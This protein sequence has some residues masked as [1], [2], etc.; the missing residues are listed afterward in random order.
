MTRRL[1]AGYL[2]LV[3]LVLLGLEIP[4]GLLFVRAETSRL[5]NGIER[6]AGMLAELAEERIEENDTDELPELAADY[7][8]R[9]GARVVIVDRTGAVLTDSASLTP[10]GTDLS[11]RPDIAT[12]LRNRT[13][14]GTAP[15]PDSGTET[16]YVTVP[17]AS[18]ETI[19]GALRLSHPTDVLAG[20]VRDICLTLALTGLGVLAV[21][22]LIALAL[23]R[24]IIRPVHALER[25]TTQ[26]ADGTLTDPPATHL[27]PPEL[28]RLAASFTHT[29]TR[30]Q[31]LLASQRAFAAEASHQLK[32]PLTA[33]RIR[34]ENFEPHL[35]PA[36]HD[37]LD[38]AIDE[39]ERLAR[40]I[41][42][43]LS[44]ARLES[45]ATTPETTD[46]DAVI[47]DRAATWTAFAAEHRVHIITTGHPAGHVWAIPGAPEQI[48]D[49][50]LANALRVSPPG[51]T[52][53]LATRPGPEGVELHVIDQGPGMS[54]AERSRAFDRFWRASDAH[55]DGTGL[56]LPIVEQLTLASGGRITLEAAPRG[57]LDAVV[58][59][60]PA[61]TTPPT[62]RTARVPHRRG[63]L[64][65]A[66][67]DPL[68]ART[69]VATTAASPARHR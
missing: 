27:G 10:V 4:F 29:A 33:L 54:E 64:P 63:P 17:G 39:T 52:I 62:E 7:A 19:R 67:G 32:T 37:S 69:P 8:E 3:L 53:T 60:R 15:D 18:G 66:P 45:T 42:G 55:H 57:G 22:T 13:T 47:A 49:N 14:V 26:L 28:R 43:L 35:D 9:T 23:A 5:S 65:T 34:L 44:L 24:W 48:I 36:V 68:G 11:A 6:D 1:L 50:L 2:G 25:A 16:R 40:M 31:H 12:A 51:T 21:A 61:R 59:L 58:L 38:E 20:R 41:Q 30:L 56:G 46:L